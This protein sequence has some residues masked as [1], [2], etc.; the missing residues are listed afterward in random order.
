VVRQFEATDQHAARQLILEGLGGHFGFIDETLNPDLDDIRS[1]FADGIFVVA[2]I[3]DVVVGTGGFHRQVDGTA[4]VVRMSTAAPHRRNGIGR[5][6]LT[7]LIEHARTSDG[8]TRIT[9]ATNADWHDAVGFYRA[10]G[11]TELLRTD[12]GVVFGLTL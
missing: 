9:L 10:S 5:A 6:V 7:S 11:F 8:C 4:N 12:A 2:L 1:S 3:G